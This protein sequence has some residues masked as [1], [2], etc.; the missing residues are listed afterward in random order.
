M[1][2][3]ECIVS[4]WGSIRL[5]FSALDYSASQ[6]SPQGSLVRRQWHP[7]AST[8]TRP[9]PDLSHL[10][11]FLFHLS[12]QI[13]SPF[14][15]Y[16]RSTESGH[17]HPLYTTRPRKPPFRHLLSRPPDIS[18]SPFPA[19]PPSQVFYGP[20]PGAS[21]RDRPALR[22]PV[23]PSYVIVH[24]AHLP[25]RHQHPRRVPRHFPIPLSL[26]TKQPTQQPATMAPPIEI[27]IPTTSLSAPAEAR[28]RVVSA[29]ER[30]D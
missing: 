30:P 27:S 16:S 12:F 18:L 23:P 25:P 15:R 6:L 8:V 9:R 17:P 7:R 4:D 1:S 29:E 2:M 19:R 20:R 10:H 24:S 28:S 22:V 21:S 14:L 5:G 3:A 26:Y 13:L 11:L